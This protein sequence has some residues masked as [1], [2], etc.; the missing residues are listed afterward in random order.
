MSDL[1]YRIADAILGTGIV[2]VA[3]AGHMADAVLAELNM[4]TEHSY[5]TTYPKHPV[6][7]VRYTRHVTEW[8]ADG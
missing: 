1:R 5:G 4:T 3:A 2:G 7:D 6:T 8:R